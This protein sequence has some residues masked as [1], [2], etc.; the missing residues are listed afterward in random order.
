MKRVLNVGGGT[1]KIRI[2][3]RYDGWDHVLLDIAPSDEADLVMD[4]RELQ[5]L[6]A[7]S[8]DAVYCSHNL[9]QYH[10]HVAEAVLKGFV[11]VLRPE[12]FAEIH[13]PDLGSVMRRVARD[14]LDI[15][16]VLYTL[17][18]GSPILIRDVIYG[19]HKEILSGN[20]F[21]A[22]KTGF[23][24]KSLHNTIKNGGFATVMIASYWEFALMA[25]AFVQ[26]TTTERFQEVL[27][28][29]I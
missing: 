6:D 29:T 7:Q 20:P 2:P 5:K 23:T 28:K 22:H 27:G 18:N 9:E 12:G 15:D 19:Y 8:F 25:F 21:F 11:H 14:N 4:A 26:P 13:V 16:D 24:L 17:P 1:K 3:S 10:R